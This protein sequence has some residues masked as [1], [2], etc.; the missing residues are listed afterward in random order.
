MIN[1]KAGELVLVGH[2]EEKS[3]SHLQHFWRNGMCALHVSPVHYRSSAESLDRILHI[4]STTDNYPI[5]SKKLL[6]LN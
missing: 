3:V 1:K 5:P 2:L 4:S 6:N